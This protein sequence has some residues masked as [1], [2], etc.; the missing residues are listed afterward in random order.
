MPAAEQEGLAMWARVWGCEEAVRGV[1]EGERGVK[2]GEWGE[3][4]SGQA[5]ATNLVVYAPDEAAEP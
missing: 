1:K 5:E 3:G 4:G 2:E